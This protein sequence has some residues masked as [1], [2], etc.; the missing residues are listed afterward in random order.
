MMHCLNYC[1]LIL[2]L[3]KSVYM[4]IKTCYIINKLQ[5][6]DASRCSLLADTAIGLDA[7]LLQVFFWGVL[8]HK[9]MAILVCARPT[10]I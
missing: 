9:C 7:L 1:L 8:Q 4:I 6:A 5:V 2:F 3:L 10:M